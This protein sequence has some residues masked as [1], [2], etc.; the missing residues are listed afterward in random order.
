MI[1]KYLRKTRKK[2][3]KSGAPV[4]ETPCPECAEM[5]D[6]AGLLEGREA[7]GRSPEQRMERIEALAEA[8]VERIETQASL[9]AEWFRQLAAQVPTGKGFYHEEI[10]NLRVEPTDEEWRELITGVVDKVWVE[11][12]G[13][14]TLE[15]PFTSSAPITIDKDTTVG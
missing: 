12:D 11:N 10:P 4:E 7:Q 9:A 1:P 14:L 5:L 13:S 6:I 8:L 15:G 3:T 2:R